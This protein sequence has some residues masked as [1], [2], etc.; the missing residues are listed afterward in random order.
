MDYTKYV[1]KDN[2]KLTSLLEGKDNLFIV[3]CN[4][5]FKEF[6]TVEEPELAEFKELALAQGKTVTGAESLDFLCNSI[7]T[8]Q[9]LDGK[10]PE[11]TENIIVIS[12]GL[13][14]Q[15]IAEMEG[16]SAPVHTR[17]DGTPEGDRAQ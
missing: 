14:V 3:S 7:Q 9:K 11:G 5:C 10:V 12:C 6:K 17:T 13:G 8:R 2:E 16:L 4:K 1:L 15:T